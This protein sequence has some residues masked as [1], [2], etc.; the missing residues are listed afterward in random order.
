MF[1]LFKLK[2]S[3]RRLNDRLHG[4]G[5]SL[6]P[7][8][9]VT[10]I[11]IESINVYLYAVVIVEGRVFIRIN[12]KINNHSNTIMLICCHL[13]P[14][15]TLIYSLKWIPGTSLHEREREYLYWCWFMSMWPFQSISYLDRSLEKEDFDIKY[16][17]LLK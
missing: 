11:Y 7:S 3:W 16:S 10:G 6:I 13:L 9:V 14:L 17:K 4:G 2:Q 12:R 8:G 1:N 15:Q 5:A